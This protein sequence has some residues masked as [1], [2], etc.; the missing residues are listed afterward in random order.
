MRVNPGHPEAAIYVGALLAEQHKYD[1]SIKYFEELTKNSAFKE[2]EKAYYYIGRVR[3]EQGAR[4]NMPRRKR[5]LAKRSTKKP[6]YPEAAVA[7]AMLLRA[8]S[9]EKQM[10]EL[11]KSLSGKIWSRSRNGPPVESLLFGKRRF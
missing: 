6:E 11:L 1:E 2:P 5:L 10:E 7:L 8:E 3:S 9:K 4:I